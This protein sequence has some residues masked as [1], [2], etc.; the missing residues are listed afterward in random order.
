MDK[1]DTD[2]RAMVKNL[3]MMLEEAKNKISELTELLGYMS[4]EHDIEKYYDE[5]AQLAMDSNNP[6]AGGGNQSAAAVSTVGGG[7]NRG[8]AHKA[9]SS[10][11]PSNSQ[12]T[13]NFSQKR[14]P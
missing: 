4:S 11:M 14:S 6:P 10:D 9:G 12:L 5:A 2:E 13:Q 3:Q 1:D 8:G 7:Q